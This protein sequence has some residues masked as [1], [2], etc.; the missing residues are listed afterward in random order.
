MNLGDKGKE[1]LLALY[2]KTWENGHV[3]KLWK[4]AT[5]NPILK[6]GKKTDQR[7]SYRP[8]DLT[9]CVG[10]LVERMIKGGRGVFHS[11]KK[12]VGGRGFPLHV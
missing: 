12:S 1:V 5:I 4:L 6:K 8:S 3:P 9:S 10:K 2:N 7:T 11:C